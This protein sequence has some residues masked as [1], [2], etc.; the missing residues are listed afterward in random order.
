MSIPDSP[1]DREARRHL[2]GLVTIRAAA[3]DT[4]GSLAVVEERTSRGY[5]TPPHVHHREDETLFVIDGV[6]EYTVDGHTATASAGEAAFLPRGRPHSFTV[7]SAEAHFLVIVTPGGFETFFAEVSPPAADAT[8]QART[9]FADMVASA[10]ALGTTV[11]TDGEPALAAARILTTL[12]NP[13]QLSAAYRTIEDVVAGTGPLPV[14]TDALIDLLGEAAVRV[15]EHPVHG[16]TLI[17]LGILTEREPRAESRVRAA[18]RKVLTGVDADWPESTTLAAAY[19]GAHFPADADAIMAALGGTHL[20]EPDLARL[21]RCLHRPDPTSPATLNGLG[22]AWPSPTI[23][24][25]DSAERDL[26]RGWRAGL[27][28]TPELAAQLWQAE[29]TAL[30]AYLGAQAEY[31]VER[32]SGV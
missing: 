21:R 13:A 30:L 28:L 4:N 1:A 12:A 7:V 14:A 11:F 16:R 6:V 22:R 20:T 25:L 19:L 29:T 3:A 26:D 9:R 5:T 2:G 32:S 18:M 31:A 23:W 8:D 15:G 17:L 24:A 27:G 10:A